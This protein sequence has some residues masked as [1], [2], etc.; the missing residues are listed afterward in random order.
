M[1]MRAE[2]DLGKGGDQYRAAAA[3]EDQ[4]EGPNEFSSG[5]FHQGHGI[6]P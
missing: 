1:A 2:A 3:A 6:S 5:S 4:P